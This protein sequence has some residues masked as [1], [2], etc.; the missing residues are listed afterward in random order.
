MVG[1]VLADNHKM[2]R[3]MTSLGFSIL[4]HPDGPSM[5]RVAKQLQE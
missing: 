3:L 2:L 1:D 5:K 4:P